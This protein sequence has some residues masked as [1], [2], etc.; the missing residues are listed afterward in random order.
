LQSR[1]RISD[2]R[3][4]GNQFC[5]SVKQLRSEMPEFIGSS[6]VIEMFIVISR[7]IACGSQVPANSKAAILH[8]MPKQS[9][10]S[11]VANSSNVLNA[12]GTPNG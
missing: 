6:K 4:T 2:R 10:L 5:E 8:Q 1:Q 3:P 12:H 11:E 9:E 7:S